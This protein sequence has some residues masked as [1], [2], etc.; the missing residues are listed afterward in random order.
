MRAVELLRARSGAWLLGVL[1]AAPGTPPDAR[2]AG[3]ANSAQAKPP[4]PS[5]TGKE[6]PQGSDIPVPAL[7]AAPKPAPSDPTELPAAFSK[8]TPTSVADLRVIQ[9]RVERLVRRLAP[10]V[11][12]V[13]VG[14]ASGSGVII[15]SNGL[16]LTAGHVCGGPDREVRFT[17]PD[18]KTARG[19]TLGADLDTDTGLM[20]ITGRGSWPYA[21]LGDL[22]Q[23]RT[24]DWVLAMGHPGGFD[25]RRSLVVRLG[26]IIRLEPEI[27]QT[28]CTISPGD[29][30]GPLFDM[31]GRVIG[32]HSLISSSLAEN[33]H[34][35]ITEYYD[36]WEVLAT[37]TSGGD[38]VPPPRAYAG[39][40]VVDDSAGCRL[41]AVDENSPATK[42]GLKA[43]DLVLKVNGREI[44]VSAS[45]ERWVA[46][47]EPGETLSLEVKRGDKLLALEVK[48]AAP[49]RRK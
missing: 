5:A 3:G 13:E 25:L 40:R 6:R 43:G 1:L 31:H 41:T 29:S 18:G 23:A 27:L 15:S 24:G 28:D 48:L 10:A 14:H 47:A 34:V 35:P 9:Q 33:F 21:V 16:V 36:G 12:A 22:Q 30:G 19:K 44:K 17:F 32:I 46:E 45:F 2:G 49:P 26:R 8:A 7:L 37:G 11:V 42:A 4:A 39:A 20:K 38:P